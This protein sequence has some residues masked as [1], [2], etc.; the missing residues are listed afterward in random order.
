MN[1][2]K[3][4]GRVYLV[5][6]GP[7]DPDLITRRGYAL[8][9]TCDAVVYDN[10]VSRELLAELPARVEC[11]Y[12]GKQAGRHTLPQEQIN[13][14]LVRLA[15]Q[16]KNVVRL[17][18]GDPFVFGRG[19]E[20]ALAL[21]EHGIPFSVVPGITAGIAG[22]AYAGIP[23]T[24]RGKSGHVVFVTGH[25]T[26]GPDAADVPWSKLA[27]LRN[28]TLVGYMGVAQLPAIVERLLAEGMPPDRPAAVIERATSTAQ[29]TITA[30]LC[31]LP[32]RAAQADVKPPALFVIGEVISLHDRLDWFETLPLFG[33]RVLLVQP[34]PHAEELGCRLRELGAE[35]SNLRVFHIKSEYDRRAWARVQARTRPGDWLHFSEAPG[36]ANFLEMWRKQGKDIRALSIYSIAVAGVDAESELNAAG[37]I[38][39]LITTSEIESDIAAEMADQLDLQDRRV[40]MVR[41]TMA[42]AG[43][44]LRPPGSGAEIIPMIVYR[45]MP[46]VLEQN[47]LEQLTINFPHMLLLPGTTAIRAVAEFLTIDGFKKLANNTTCV[48][49]GASAVDAARTLGITVIESPVTAIDT[50]V[51]LILDS[52]SKRRDTR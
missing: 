19:G 45:R 43:S 32:H 23:V 30:P 12:V 10:L 52:A 14:L 40:V 41:G 50:I 38:P 31:E 22:P 2:N 13:E 25:E 9:S 48:A 16:G 21:A 29:R 27:G 39:D 24:H 18:G 20:E 17:K 47:D 35:F 11:H 46:A 5:G 15:G 6:A 26:S 51:Q 7:G 37:I 49:L 44:D 33:R 28:G 1:D 3:F 4:T 34:F 8:L 42:D 36:V